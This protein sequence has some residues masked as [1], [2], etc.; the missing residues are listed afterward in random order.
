MGRVGEL[1]GLDVLSHDGLAVATDGG[2]G[3]TNVMAAVSGH[4]VSNEL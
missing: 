1:S 3:E 4:D 2:D